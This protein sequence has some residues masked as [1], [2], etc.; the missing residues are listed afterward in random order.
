MIIGQYSR[1]DIGEYC[2]DKTR[3]VNHVYVLEL[4]AGSGINMGGI[5]ITPDIF[6]EDQRHATELKNFK[7]DGKFRGKGLGSLLM[8]K[9]V[10]ISEEVGMKTIKVGLGNERTLSAFCANF[11]E[12]QVTFYRRP[13]AHPRLV[14]LPGGREHAEDMLNAM[15]EEQFPDNPDS[16]EHLRANPRF[17]YAQAVL[18]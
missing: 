13:P 9:A 17:L 10:E 6:A 5:F 12:E 11:E 4:M 7:I 14:R 15:R 3:I 1:P 16:S 18:V 8:G 2:L